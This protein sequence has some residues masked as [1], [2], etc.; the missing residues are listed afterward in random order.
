MSDLGG[1]SVSPRWLVVLAWALVLVA[2]PAGAHAQ[3]PEL[4]GH[5][6]VPSSLVA[7]SFID[8]EVSS[9]SEASVTDFSFEPSLPSFTTPFVQLPQRLHGSFISPTQTIGGGVA[10]TDFLSVNAQLIA[11]G[12]LPIDTVSALAVGGHGAWGEAI[13]AALGLLRTGP[14]QLTLR[15]DFTALELESVIPTFLPSSPLVS[16]DVWGVRPAL[17]AALTLIPRVGLQGSF[18]YEWQDYAIGAGDDISTVTGALAGTFALDPAPLVALVGA[19]VSH[20]FGRDVFTPTA[21][22]VFGPDRTAWNIEAGLYVTVRRE[23]DLGVLGRIQLAA[24]DHNDHFHGVFR[25]GYYF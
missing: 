18:T 13:G 17:A 6:Y 25:L 12:I 8:T 4:E 7:W 1:Q 21:D 19:S 2:L 10:V 22:A 11:T 14:F 16:G 23:L 9:T 20:Q 5:R 24:G 3:V 15:A